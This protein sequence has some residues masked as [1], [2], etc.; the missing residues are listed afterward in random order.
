MWGGSIKINNAVVY[1]NG[2]GYEYYG[3]AGIGGGVS[4]IYGFW[5][6]EF[7]ISIADSEIHVSKGCPYASYIGAGGMRSEQTNYKIIPSAKV[8][9]SHIYDESGNE[10][11]Q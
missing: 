6:T 3:G 8:T 1:A 11:T 10:I 5:Q 2:G 4:S 7:D 9:N